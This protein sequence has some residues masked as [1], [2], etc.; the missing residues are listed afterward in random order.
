MLFRRT[1]FLACAAL[2]F[3]ACDVISGLSEFSV[4]AGDAAVSGGCTRHEDCASAAQSDGADFC[5]RATGRC[6]ALTSADCSV[7]AGPATDDDA[8]LLGSLFSTQGAQAAV[9]L[10]RQ[11]SV[12]LAVEELN[13][14]GGLPI[15]ANGKTRPLVLVACD[16][17][18]DVLRAGRHLASDLQVSAIIG[19]NTSQDTLDLAKNLAI[20]AGT[21]LITPTGVASAI[22]DLNDRDLVW[23][24]AP[25]DTQ[26][27]RLMIKEINDLERDLRSERGGSDLKLGVLFR[28]DALGQGTRA[29]L[30]ALMFNGASLLDASNGARVRIDA[31]DPASK[32]QS[33][34]V[35]TYLDFAPD[36]LVL[37]GTGEAVS[38]LLKPLEAG[39]ATGPHP[40][41]ARPQYVLTDS[42]KVPELLTLVVAQ[43]ELASRVRGTG[44]SAMPDSIPVRDA[45]RIDYAIRFPDG[46]DPGSSGLGTSYDATYAV[47]YALASQRDQ[48]VSGASVARGLRQLGSGERVAIQQTSILSALGELTRGRSISAI[49]TQAPLVW[50]ERGAVAAGRIEIWCVG[51]DAEGKSAFYT[52]SGLTAEIATQETSGENRVCGI[53]PTEVA[54]PDDTTPLPQTSSGAPSSA[55]RAAAGSGGRN[56]DGAGAGGR[57]ASAGAGGSGEA[58]SLFGGLLGGNG[59]L[60][61]KSVIACGDD[62]CNRADGEYCCTKRLYDTQAQSVPEDF[63]CE[64]EPADCAFATYCRHDNDCPDGEVC[65]LG[66]DHMQC[67]PSLSCTTGRLPCNTSDEC[68]AGVRCCFSPVGG[69]GTLCDGICPSVL[70]RSIVLCSDDRVCASLALGSRCVPDQRYPTLKTCTD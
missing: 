52:S 19:P 61:S 6:V 37:I 30:D 8:L 10:A 45:F 34:L 70:P 42:S 39:W 21:A 65:C 9:N 13:A 53:H 3:T 26:R 16:E 22:A 56:A 49:G 38:Q 2:L 33:A 4:R 51:S 47:A 44:V 66:S 54:V 57:R 67:T 20:A 25:N 35:S 15:G 5:L 27:G 29:S 40:D 48:D 62:E 55:G 1:A 46:G 23:Q 60:A 63:S 43:N 7:A 64:T 11:H 18:A 14:A 31:Y 32:D 12:T 69:G 17:A 41:A 59:A 68:S 28:D 50:D 24:M 58:G 36:I